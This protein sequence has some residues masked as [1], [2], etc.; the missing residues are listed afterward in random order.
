[1]KKLFFG[2]AC[3]IGLM[4]FASC[5]QEVIDDIMAQKPTV[6]FVSGEGF[7]SGNTGAYIGTQ[8]NF[9]VRIAPN[10]SSESELAH[11]DF[12]ITDLAGNTVFNE[13]P[14]ITNPASDSTFSFSFTPATASTYAVTAT[15]TDKAGK[16]NVAMLTVDY[17]EPISESIGTYTGTITL[18]GHIKSNEIAGYQTYDQDMDPEELATTIT[19][20]SVGENGHVRATLDIDGTPVSLYGTMAEDGTITFD[21]FNFSKTINLF[22]DV[23]LNLT[24]ELTGRIGEDDVLT[25]EGPANGS[26]KTQVFIAYLEVNFEGNIEGRLEKVAE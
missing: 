26:G 17:V 21:T 20:G 16:S 19:I 8:L 13:N 18:S 2:L 7:I 11:F 6:E 24:M 15:V 12:S 23:T 14:E 4:F 9:K 22:V 10:T 3:L 25:L 5:T 1:M